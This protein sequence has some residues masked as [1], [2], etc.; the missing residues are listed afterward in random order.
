MNVLHRDI[1]AIKMRFVRI[2]KHHTHVLVLLVTLAM[3]SHVQK[4]N[5]KYAYLNVGFGT[6]KLADVNQSKM[7]LACN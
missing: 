6:V 7:K 1:N 5:L 2:H 4:L 3:A